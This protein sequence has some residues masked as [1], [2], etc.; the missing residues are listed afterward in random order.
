MLESIHDMLLRRML[1]GL[2]LGLLTTNLSLGHQSL[3]S[4][5]Y[6]AFSGSCKCDRVITISPT[7]GGQESPPPLSSACGAPPLDIESRLGSITAGLFAFGSMYGLIAFGSIPGGG[8]ACI[9]CI[10]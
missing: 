3:I 6:V 2:G 4:L 5:G 7:A 10:C 1:L 9:C 8:C